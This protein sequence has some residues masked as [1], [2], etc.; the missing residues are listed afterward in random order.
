MQILK[1]AVERKY[2]AQYLKWGLQL[3][4]MENW[5]QTEM[6]PLSEIFG[7]SISLAGV[8]PCMSPPFSPARDKVSGSTKLLI[9]HHLKTASFQ[10]TY[11]YSL[12]DTQ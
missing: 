11:F 5:Q 2:E 6:L 8:L 10:N 7:L 1:I 4:T 12:I 3:W 9:T